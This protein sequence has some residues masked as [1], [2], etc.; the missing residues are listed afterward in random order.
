ESLDWKS[1]R[2]IQE[3]NSKWLQ[4]RKVK[5]F[6]SLI[7][8]DSLENGVSSL[9]QTVGVGK[10]RPN[11]LLMGFKENWQTCDMKET[12]D[13]FDII[14]QVV[15]AHMSLC[16]LRVQGGTDYSSYFET[17]E[18][19]PIVP[20]LD[21][22]GNLVTSFKPPDL[23]IPLETVI[24]ET[25]T[26]DGVPLP[27]IVISSKADEDFKQMKIAN[28]F[29]DR[30]E[31]GIIDVWWLYDDGGLTLLLPYLL[32][33]RAQFK[34]CKLRVFSVAQ[35]HTNIGE[36]QRNLSALLQK[37][38]I[39]FNDLTVVSAEGE[40]LHE[41]STQ[42]FKKTISKFL[43]KDESQKDPTTVTRALLNTF[44]NRTNQFLR[45][46]EL[47]EKHS[48]SS[49]MIV[50]TLPLPRKEGATAPLYMAWLDILTRDLPPFLLVRGNQT[51]VLTFYS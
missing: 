35:D 33:T 9:I 49:N 24:E 26:D 43:S 22:K 51:S 2:L 50:M 31:K 37:F 25:P 40:P 45:L 20:I 47:L 18:G 15:Y 34:G 17:P 41:E 19:L 48:K 7:E 8:A 11:I 6:Y 10:M 16:I 46:R 12:V 4:E 44:K 27:Y 30:Q 42:M 36:E 1:R 39:P 5:A 28:L 23:K 32:T 38:R 13:Y 21:P 14:H 3:L 29:H